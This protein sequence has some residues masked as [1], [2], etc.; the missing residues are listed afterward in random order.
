[1]KNLMVIKYNREMV[2]LEEINNLLF[3]LLITKRCNE[4]PEG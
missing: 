2:E 3:R 1:M 4:E